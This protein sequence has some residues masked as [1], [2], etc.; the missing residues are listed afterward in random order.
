MSAKVDYPEFMF[1]QIS[2]LIE[3]TGKGDA[4]YT[5]KTKVIDIL[6]VLESLLAY[7]IYTTCLTTEDVREASE[8]SYVSIKKQAVA[9]LRKNPPKPE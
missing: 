7:T 9:M 5:A 4:E 1:S 2:K 3:N 6:N 8:D